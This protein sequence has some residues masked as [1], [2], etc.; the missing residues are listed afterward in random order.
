MFAGAAFTDAADINADNTEAVDLLTTLGIIKG[1][2]DGSF[3][4]EG[5]VTRAEMAKMIYTIRNDGNDDAS[6]YESVTTSFTDISGHWAEG[7]V[8]YLQNTG[9]VA[10]KSAT[11]FDPDSQVTT[12]EAMKMALVLAGYRA[13]KAELTGTNWLNNTVS[14]ATTVGMTKDV[15]SAIAGGCTRQDAAQI[16]FNTLTD[17]WAVQWSDVTNSFLNDSEAG[18]AWG[19]ARITVGRKWM[20]LSVLVGRMVSSGDLVIAN[21]NGAGGITAA[22]AAGKDRFTVDVDSIDDRDLDAGVNP[23]MTLKDGKDHTDLVGQEV[24]VLRGDKIDEVYGVYATGTSNV[25]ETT[26]D[27]IDVV[28]AT[29]GLK[30]KTDGVTYDTTAATVFDDGKY[31]AAVAAVFTANGQKVADSVKIIDWDNDGKYETVLTV[32]ANVAELS[33]VGSSSVSLGAVG[34]RDMYAATPILTSRSIDSVDYTIYDGA[35]KG[36]YVVITKNLYNGT[37]NIEKAETLEGTVNGLVDN[38]RK[39]RIDGNWYT[40]ANDNSAARNTRVIPGS[41]VTFTNGDAVSLVLV[42]DI[43][44]YAKSASGNDAN[45]TVL[46]PYQVQAD[47]NIYGSWNEAKVILANGDKKTVTIATIDGVA[48]G[49]FNKAIVG[50]MYYYDINNDGDYILTTLSAAQTA[51][52]D[53]VAADNN[54]IDKA[55]GDKTYGTRTIAD[56]AVVFAMI[57]ANDAKVYSGKAVKDVV[58]AL[59]N[60]GQTNLGQALI[61][62]EAGFTYTRMMNIA[63]GAEIDDTALYA[64]VLDSSVSSISANA[65]TAK[66]VVARAATGTKIME[67]TLWTKDGM[68]TANEITDADKTPIESGKLVTYTNDGEGYIKNVREVLPTN[69]ITDEGDDLMTGAIIAASGNNISLWADTNNDGIYEEIIIEADGDTIALFVDSN[70]GTTENIGQAG[71]STYNFPASKTASGMVNLNTKYI[72]GSDG[73]VKV[74]LID[75]AGDLKSEGTVA[76]EDL[77]TATLGTLPTGLT[78]VG[79]NVGDKVDLNESITVN[80][81]AAVNKT[82]YET[83]YTATGAAITGAD[84]DGSKTVTG[85]GNVDTLTLTVNGKSDTVS[86]SAQQLNVKLGNVEVDD[87][88]EGTGVYATYS[89]VASINNVKLNDN[90]PAKIG[91]TLD[92]AVTPD[93]VLEGGSNIINVTFAGVTKSVTFNAGDPVATKTVSF[94]VTTAADGSDITVASTGTA[95]QAAKITK[96]EILGDDGY[97]ATTAGTGG[98]AAKIRITFDRAMANVS[99]VET[100]TGTK[101]VQSEANVISNGQWNTEKTQ[102]TFNLGTVISGATGAD[103]VNITLG[104]DV[105]TGEGAG[106]DPTTAKITI[107]IAATTLLIT[108]TVGA[109]A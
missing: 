63:L 70:N 80:I 82:G 81:A 106:I 69:P 100:T 99:D 31:G 38:D 96:V 93:A 89:F 84:S 59:G 77:K 39:I 46:M 2:E 22:D 42:G 9:I 1:Y 12:G 53:T 30:L 57:G 33:F 56:E 29:N 8:K 74:I 71:I 16:L 92:V 94:A 102:I 40:L 25:V 11:R 98:D 7:Y 41:R 86:V 65:A 62:T 6:A 90:D 17:V 36:D 107:D 66:S 58:S 24:K 43:A 68:L 76:V 97:A 28:A 64:Y 91:D 78:Y 55:N 23:F 48:A 61:S 19:G 54:G 32:T 67:Y 108:T 103:T 101:F 105:K 4:P 10:G 88:A 83:K 34:S 47:Q 27:Q 26:M 60:W 18:L 85:D 73:N 79:K 95:A 5:T 35:A 87:I 75:T 104:T 45:R 14:R 44:Y 49:Q 51:G 15:H 109:N 50:K 37:W 21:V 3:D 13:D 72:M 52:Y 20:D